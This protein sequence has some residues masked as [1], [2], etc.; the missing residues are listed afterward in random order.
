MKG[1]NVYKGKITNE[2]VAK[3]Q[4]LLYEPV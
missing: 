3:A 2:A 4:G 1:L